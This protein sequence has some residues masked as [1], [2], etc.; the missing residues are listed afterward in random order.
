[1]QLRRGGGRGRQVTCR[2]EQLELEVFWLDE[3][4]P[5]AL[6]GGQVGYCVCTT[7]VATSFLQQL[8]LPEP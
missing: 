1:M 5:D 6:T 7:Q 3:L 2:L 4:L 8:E